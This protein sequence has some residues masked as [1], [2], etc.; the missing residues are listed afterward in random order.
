MKKLIAFLLASAL[1]FTLSACSTPPADPSPQSPSPEADTK[2]IHTETDVYTGQLPLVAEGQSVTLTVG[3]PYRSLTENYDTNDYTLWLEKTTGIDL[4]FIFF[5]EDEKEMATQLSMMLASKETLP[6]IFVGMPLGKAMINELGNQGYFLDL[7]DLF[8]KYH[9]HWEE[10]MSKAPE[11]IVEQCLALTRDPASGAMY[12]FPTCQYAQSNDRIGQLV[13]INQVWLDA[14]GREVPT[15]V[16]EL[17]EVLQLFATEDPNGN[18]EADELPAIYYSGWRADFAQY[19]INAWVFCNDDYML[20][21]TDGTLWVPYN[22]DEYREALIFLNKLYN[23]GLLS[24]LSF[25]VSEHSDMKSLYNPMEGPAICGIVG[26]HPTVICQPNSPITA[27][28]T[29][30][31]PLEAETE[32]G[33]YANIGSASYETYFMITPECKDPDLAAK[34]IDFMTGKESM[35]HQRYGTEG[36]HWRYAEEGELNANGEQADFFVID[37]SPYSNQN[38][39]VWHSGWGLGNTGWSSTVYKDMGDWTAVRHQ[40]HN[41]ILPK[42]YQAEQPKEIVYNLTYTEEEN[43]VVADLRTMLKEY[44]LQQRSLFISGNLDPNNDADW[45]TYLADLELQGIN[46]WL[47]ASQSAYDRMMGK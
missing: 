14:I 27:E 18:G 17:Y 2:I 43:T 41:T 38:N 29:G 42:Y 33:G 4:E 34:F 20:N 19:V 26:G 6:E 31:G 24:P 1:L 21:A 45:E 46:D 44:I 10:S 7:T 35:L 30:M 5:S 13:T 37:S 23:E 15:N 11:G 25:S 47:S 3:M 32:L 39:I 16:D 22:T 8:E 36:V 12:A 9:V 28:Y 40:I